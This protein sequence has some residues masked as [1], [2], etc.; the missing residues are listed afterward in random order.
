MPFEGAGAISQWRIELDKDLAQFD[1]DTISDV[2]MHVRYTA[3]E[4]G[5]QLKDVSKSYI[6]SI[7]KEITKSPFVRGISVSHG[8]PNQW[9]EFLYPISNAANENQ[10][11][12]LP[13]K[14]ERFSLLFR[15]KPIK[16]DKIDVFLILKD[17][18]IYR[19]VD[20][21]NEIIYKPLKLHIIPPPQPG[22]GQEQEA[23]PVF[24]DP[25]ITFGGLPHKVINFKDMPNQNPK[26]ID[27]E[28]YV[29]KIEARQTD[30]FDIIGALTVTKRTTRRE[31]YYTIGST[32][33]RRSYCRSPL[34]G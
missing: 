20:D 13:L 29:W 10:T 18:S 24:L 9:H 11:L 15:E 25:D 6:K 3:R 34:C 30:I 12:T 31:N 22:Q 17:K 32:S 23:I 2:V 26:I 27:N 5:E 16:I 28:N 33:D 1:L 8:F 14:P 21:A 19:K 7:L 4:G